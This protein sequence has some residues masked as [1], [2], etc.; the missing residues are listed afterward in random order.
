MTSQINIKKLFFNFL[1]LVYKVCNG[2][3]GPNVLLCS[4]RTGVVVRSTDVLFTLQS[5]PNKECETTSYYNISDPVQNLQ[6]ICDRAR[7]RSICEIPRDF[8]VRIFTTRYLI[9]ESYHPVPMRYQV[10]F[11]CLG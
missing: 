5:N 3:L 11:D 4:P 2:D 9:P 1:C 10:R 8:S 7:D 6:K